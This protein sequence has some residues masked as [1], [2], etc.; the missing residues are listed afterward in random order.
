[1]DTIK[2]GKFIAECRKA[3]GL[4]QTILAEKLG[5]TNRAVSKWETGKSLPDASI[6]LELCDILEISVNELLNGEKIVMDNYKEIAENTLKDMVELE[7]KKNKII[8]KAEFFIT[9]S[10]V[11]ISLIMIV[12]GAYTAEKT[13]VITLILIYAGA[14]YVFSSCIFGVLLEH[15]SGYYECKNCRHR[16]SPSKKDVIF[17]VHY[18]S[19]RILKCPKCKKKDWHIKVLSK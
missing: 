12:C 13:P 1:M 10:S 4:T 16:H 18:G 8:E 7:K 17:S 15:D 2:T 6:M 9:I 5:I 3:K 11:I 19:D 14:V